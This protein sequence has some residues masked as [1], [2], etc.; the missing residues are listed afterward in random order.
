MFRR[1]KDFFLL[2]TSLVRDPKVPGRS[3]WLPWI[4]VAYLLFPLD[5][6]PD[7][8]P[9]LGQA[10][11]LT[12]IITLVMMAVNAISDKTYA[13]HKK[14]KYPDA[15]DVTPEGSHSYNKQ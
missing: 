7:F 10:D 3:K 1:L 2:Y 11:D 15:I 14:E 5:I 6:L 9:L 13:E 8:I 4:A 12:V